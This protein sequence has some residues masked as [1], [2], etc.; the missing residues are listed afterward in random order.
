MLKYNKDAARLSLA[1]LYNK[2]YKAVFKSFKTIAGKIQE[3]YDEI[4]NFFINRSTN[5]SAESI[6]ANIKAFRVSL[7]V[8]I[9]I[10]FFSLD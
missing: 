9:D 5:V 3:Y 10:K 8:V 2:A 1:S 6:N 4:L 7:R